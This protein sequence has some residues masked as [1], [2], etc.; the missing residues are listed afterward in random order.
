MGNGAGRIGLRQTLSAEQSRLDPVVEAQ[1]RL[2]RG[3][4]TGMG[5]QVAAGQHRQ[6]TER[7]RAPKEAAPV[8][9]FQLRPDLGHAD[10]RFATLIAHRLS[11]ISAGT[12]TIIDFSVRGWTITSAT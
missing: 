10:G 11:S 6:R 12:A 1:D 5:R 9:P 2:Q 7:E 3:V 8:Q 4:D